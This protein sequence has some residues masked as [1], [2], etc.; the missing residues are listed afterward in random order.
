MG[1]TLDLETLRAALDADPDRVYVLDADGRYLFFNQTVRA[2]TRGPALDVLLGRTPTH[3]LP[4][5]VARPME[6]MLQRSLNGEVLRER[7]TLPTPDGP[8]VY[9]T[10]TVPVRDATGA[11]AGLV[12]RQRDIT[13]EEVARER[14]RQDVEL[15][16]AV[17]ALTRAAATETPTPEILGRAADAARSLVG[18]GA[19]A[20]MR[21]SRG[22]VVVRAVSGSLD[23]VAVGDRCT[24]TQA[25]ASLAAIRERRPV[26][27][28]VDPEARVRADLAVAIAV[29]IRTNGRIWGALVAWP[30]RRREPDEGIPPALAQL[31]DVVG[32]ALD[33]SASRR[34]LAS[35]ALTDPMTGLPNARAVRERLAAEVA[36]ARRH[37]RPLVLSQIDLDR[38]K[39]INDVHGHAAG[40][41]V[42]R[43]VGAALRT[44]A[45]GGDI[46]GRMGGE[47][48]VWVMRETELAQAIAAVGRLRSRIATTGPTGG[49]PVT[50][51]VG[52]AALGPDDDARSLEAAADLA[53]YQAKAD[54]RDLTRVCAVAGGVVDP[55]ARAALVEHDRIVEG[56]RAIAR[57]RAGNPRLP[58]QW[59]RRAEGEARAAG[60]A[61]R[62]VR[63]LRDVASLVGVDPGLAAIVLD[64]E[65][66]AWLRGEG[67]GGRILLAVATAADAALATQPLST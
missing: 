60:W 37:A 46:V 65:Q 28:H 61:E 16:A 10:S 63:R 11:V 30:D 33:V 58:S 17:A 9:D 47:E 27:F 20:V 7:R 49:A 35:L 40:D 4:A 52:L 6:E 29:P 36:H 51:S 32:L 18:E 59:A 34:K 64:S 38:F 26:Q 12:L 14:L 43:A 53:V 39:L 48:F 22:S 13:N 3:G 31:A 19:A 55:A 5:H 54:G 67:D 56:L 44:T 8:R 25:P 15:Q 23:G 24:P 41:A 42:L 62:E 1:S 21:R 45:R 2:T 50:A 66:A 57:R